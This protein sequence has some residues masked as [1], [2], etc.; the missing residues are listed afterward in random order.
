[1][2]TLLVNDGS[3]AAQVKAGRDANQLVTVTLSEGAWS[4]YTAT[5]DG[6]GFAIYG[7]AHHP[8]ALTIANPTTLE[9]KTFT[10]EVAGRYLVR[11]VATNTGTSAQEVLTALYEVSS[12][13]GAE[14]LPA[15]REQ[16]EYDA[17]TG[18]ARAV[19]EQ[20]HANLLMRGGRKCV[21]V[22]NG[23]TQDLFLGETASLSF[24][25][26]HASAGQDGDDMEEHLSDIVLTAEKVAATN[27]NVVS[28][29]IGVCSENI[30]VGAHGTLILEGPLPMDTSG[31]LS[32]G[33]PVFVS[34][35]SVLSASAGTN[36]RRLGTVIH[37][38][39]TTMATVEG[40]SVWIDGAP[41]R[42]V[43]DGKDWVAAGTQGT[44]IK[45]IEA[46][47]VFGWRDITSG[48][49]VRPTG[50]NSPTLSIF[51][52]SIRQFEFTPGLTETFHEYHMPHDY[53]PGTDVHI[54]THWAQNV[55]D[56][57]GAGG[58]PGDV[59]WY[60][61]CTY[62]KGHQQAA[63]VAPVTVSVVQTASGTQYYHMVA[64]T[65]L[66]A[67]SGAGGLLD[68]D[69]LEPDGLFLVRCYRDSGDAADTLNQNPF[70]FYV[71]LHYQS[72]NLAT[73]EKA[74]SFYG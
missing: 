23:G 73:K 61:E 30:A 66:T 2:A 26:R 58:S 42:V 8:S 19:E 37:K 44:G 6:E 57:G 32:V 69:D 62:A 25:A 56:T 49:N 28:T 9:N 45:L 55:V 1:M 12:A 46:A 60:F 68:T 71:D 52:G 39:A 4:N 27:A 38:A 14:A 18:W 53:V 70:L 48:G 33:S 3:G 16:F 21:R 43:V 54:H 35:T 13:Y 36:T 31:F 10:P 41:D 59:K 47:P 20:L 65:Q 17:D 15:P 24:F 40:G 7:P 5:G 11:L 63:Y 64:E 72:T 34:N 29:H 67:A 51:L 74:P 22:I 50:P